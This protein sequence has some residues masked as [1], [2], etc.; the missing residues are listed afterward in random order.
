MYD[1]HD[2]ETVARKRQKSKKV[3]HIHEYNLKLE[4]NTG[5]YFRQEIQ[6]IFSVQEEMEAMNTVTD[7]VSYRDRTGKKF[8]RLASTEGSSSPRFPQFFLLGGPLER[9]AIHLAMEFRRWKV[10]HLATR[11]TCD[12]NWYVNGLIRFSAYQY[13]G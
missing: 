2:E 3:D 11:K 1:G 8:A 12:M 5:T 4:Q 6:R 10:K 13:Q 9:S 7:K